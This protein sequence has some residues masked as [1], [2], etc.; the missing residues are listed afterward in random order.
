MYT[1]WWV[2]MCAIT[3]D[4][5]TKINVRDSSNTS[6]SS[7]VS[8]CFC[9]CGKNTEHE[10]YSFNKCRGAEHRQVSCRYSVVQQQTKTYS[11]N[12]AGALYPANNSSHLLHLP[13]AGSHR[14]FLCLSQ[15]AGTDTSY[16]W[17][18]AALSFCYWLISHS[19]MN[20]KW[21]H[22]TT[23]CS[24]ELSTH[25][26][27]CTEKD[28][29]LPWKRE[30]SESFTFPLPNHFR[31]FNKKHKFPKHHSTATGPGTF[32]YVLFE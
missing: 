30:S 26:I 9:S 19:L 17:S 6:P 20:S 7:L 29:C 24:N 3:C 21:S 8:L 16:K 18:H 22:K 2:W 1:L 15:F 32:M 14:G 4:S 28:D 31:I 13:A 11:S 10:I 25:R 27:I 12:V 5:I 23:L